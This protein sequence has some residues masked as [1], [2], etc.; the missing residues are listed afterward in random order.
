MP[1]RRPLG[2]NIPELI[3][4]L[5]Q[6][7]YSDYRVVIRELI[8]N[9]RDALLRLPEDERLQ[10]RITLRPDPYTG[11]LEVADN[12]VGMDREEIEQFL[13]VMAQSCARLEIEPGR[14]PAADQLAGYFG[15]GFFACM[16]V[17]DGV[18]VYTSRDPALGGWKWS[19]DEQQGA[20]YALEPCQV[21]Q[22]G[23]RVV[24]RV[25]ARYV[26]ALLPEVNLARLTRQYADLVEFPVVVGTSPR[27]INRGEKPWAEPFDPELFTQ[28]LRDHELI[29][30]GDE[31][32][33]AWP[34][35]RPDQGVDGVVYLP[36][37]PT[38]KPGLAL[39]TRGLFIARST[40]FLP[41]GWDFLHGCVM[42]DSL[43]LLLSREAVARD[44]HLTR[45][46]E[47]LAAEV[48]QALVELARRRPAD[49]ARVNKV[50]GQHI[51]AAALDSPEMLS[52]LA[53][54]LSFPS[55]SD[56]RP[57]SV[58][59]LVAAAQKVQGCV[60]YVDDVS[61]FAHALLLAE[62]GLPVV[63]ASSRLDLALL[64]QVCDEFS[65]RPMRADV[66]SHR[67]IQF[68]ADARWAPVERLFGRLD[69][70]LQPRAV[71]LPETVA[72]LIGHSEEHIQ[73]ER[74]REL[75]Q[76]RDRLSEEQR[77]RLDEASRQTGEPPKP[78]L[79]LNTRHPAIRMLREALESR[80]P[81]DALGPV[82]RAIL[83]TAR[84]LS[85]ELPIGERLVSGGAAMEVCELLLRGALED[86]R[87]ATTGADGP[88]DGPGAEA[89][90]EGGDRDGRR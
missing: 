73:A 79:L 68:G 48:L 61:Q 6:H 23:T 7:L 21:Q 30:E 87:D 80:R 65:L 19:Y 16:S 69:E 67:F 20:T 25:K 40:D 28:F 75:Q 88:E 34:F 52:V 37:R 15:L 22:R 18:E 54:A 10:G 83:A 46:Q 26:D 5:T 55:A 2:A 58:S 90:P 57:L 66:A 51:K 27:P 82:A 4:L 36:G 45:L 49:L 29:A 64:E 13:S 76:H 84:M 35:H 39:Y 24:M 77:E 17:S 56:P 12:G 63:D 71:E 43:N 72:A 81:L 85:E 31:L 86:P 8:A 1:D 53:L 14:A 70:S 50:Y 38:A 41:A 62:R 78:M 47:I 59:D 74:I 11:R 33:L 89:L 42:C 3:K 44:A 9:A 32:L 60:A